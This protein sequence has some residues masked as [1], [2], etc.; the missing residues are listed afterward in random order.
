MTPGRYN[1]KRLTD[2]CP[3]YAASCGMGL[4]RRLEAIEN[5]ICPKL[6]R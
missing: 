5:V 3:G 4:W 1:R 6:A 2:D